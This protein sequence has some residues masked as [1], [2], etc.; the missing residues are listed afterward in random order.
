MLEIGN[1]YYEL[2]LDKLNGFINKN[3]GWNS[4]FVLDNLYKE[5][6]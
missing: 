3:H 5:N 4:S 6:N 1:L 2:K